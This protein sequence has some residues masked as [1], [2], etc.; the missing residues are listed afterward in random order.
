[1]AD[2]ETTPLATTLR[3]MMARRRFGVR[4]LAKASGVSEAYLHQLRIGRSPKTGQ[5]IRPSNEVLR[6]IAK[7]LAD[8]DEKLG[9]QLYSELMGSAGYLP[10][11]QADQTPAK[12]QVPPQVE[13]DSRRRIQFHRVARY[14]EELTDE[15]R[16][17]VMDFLEFLASK[18]RG[19][20]GERG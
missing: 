12:E 5:P 15:E 20:Q 11:E 18:H 17:S 14:W 7:A 8:G 13:E 2:P 6:L 19:E 3:E 10:R 4:E 16:A 1:M 9:E